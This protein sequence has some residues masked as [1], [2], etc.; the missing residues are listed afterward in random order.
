MRNM[1]GYTSICPDCSR[2]VLSWNWDLFQV[3]RHT[4]LTVRRLCF[5]HFGT[6]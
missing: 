1:W 4:D 3:L 6:S 2:Q 5:S